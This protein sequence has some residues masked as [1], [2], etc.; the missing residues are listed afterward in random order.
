MRGWAMVFAVLAAPAWAAPDPA[1]VTP[2]D[3]AGQ[4]RALAAAAPRLGALDPRQ[5]CIRVEAAQDG[6]SAKA[7]LRVARAYRVEVGG[8][9]R[10]H[11]ALSGQG[12]ST[13]HACAGVVA[14]AALDAS[15]PAWTVAAVSKPTLSGSMGEPA[16]PSGLVLRRLGANRWG[17]T[18]TTTYVGCGEVEG[19]ST[20][21]LVGLGGIN[22]AGT[23][24]GEA[25]NMGNCFNGR[26]YSQPDGE[27]CSATTVAVTVDSTKPDADAYP[28]V[29]RFDTKQGSRTRR[30]VV[31]VPF[32]PAQGKWV[33]PGAPPRS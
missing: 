30:R 31:A 28:I 12:H 15:G 8:A 26:V 27:L 6:A 5:H 23:L 1:K 33:E 22:P 32:D 21:H 13:C 9:V 7:C 20:I 17:W 16:A 11:V 3:A 10:V 2:L 25:S 14:F 4:A 18:E 29:L 19:A 24:S